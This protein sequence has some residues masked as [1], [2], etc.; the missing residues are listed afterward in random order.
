MLPGSR[1]LGGQA[2]D[3]RHS[4]RRW[5]CCERGPKI[6]G[7]RCPSWLRC[8][9][10]IE[11]HLQALAAS[12]R[13]LSKARRT[14]FA[15]SSWRAAALA[16]SGTVTLEL[17]L[18]GTP[19][20]VA[21]KVDAMIA[22]VL[23]RH[24]H[25]ALD[26]A[27]QPGA[28]RDVPSPSFIRRSARASNLAD[29]LAPLLDDSPQRARQLAALARIPAALQCRGPRPERGRGRYCPGVRGERPRLAA[30]WR[31]RE[32]SERQARLSIGTNGRSVA[33]M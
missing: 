7:R 16:A 8:A 17:A 10:S 29:A 31:S 4:A 5:P 11:Q 21:Y 32:Q 18:A 33:P 12:S 13:I 22:P 25:C 6:R 2:A 20:V 1:T 9:R 26:R 23:R 27:A 15:P 28:R 19:M 24:D 14:S 30:P 3:A